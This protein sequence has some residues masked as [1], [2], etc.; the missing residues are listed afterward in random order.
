MH[1][2]NACT[3]IETCR[4]IGLPY[5]KGEMSETVENLALQMSPN[6]H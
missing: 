2:V 3:E 4:K 1:I 5:E 6:D